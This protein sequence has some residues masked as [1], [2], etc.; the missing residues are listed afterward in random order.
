MGSRSHYVG[1]LSIHVG[2]VVPFALSWLGDGRLQRRGWALFVLASTRGG[3]D[4]GLNR[5]SDFFSA[6]T[7]RV[8][9]ASHLHLGTLPAPSPRDASSRLPPCMAG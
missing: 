1:A 6:N 9:A 5:N 8:V 4:G 2:W 7:R 3:N